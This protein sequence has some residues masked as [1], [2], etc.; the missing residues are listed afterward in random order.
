M[1]RRTGEKPLGAGGS[2][3]E[4]IDAGV[5]FD[6]LRLEEGDTFLDLACGRGLYTLAAAAYVGETGRLFALDLWE[7]GIASL[8]LEAARRGFANVSAIA[9]DVRD[10][11]PIESGVVDVCLMAAVLHD[12]V[13]IGADSAALAETARVLKPGG[14]LAVVEFKKMDGPPGPPASVRLVPEQVEKLVLPFGFTG[15]SFRDLGAY[16]YL[17]TYLRSGLEKT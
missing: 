7:E 8:I 9:G 6:E 10:R 5:L 13:A 1:N 15:K 3:F 17:V 14:L 2:S 16:H 12:F 11:I 4:L